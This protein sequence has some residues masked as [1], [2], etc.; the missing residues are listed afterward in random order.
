MKYG[1]IAKYKVKP[2]HEKHMTADMENFEQS[3]PEGWSHHTVLRS[4]TDPNEIWLCV[5]FDS[6]ESYKRNADSPDMDKEYRR[7]LEHLE[8]EPE[9]HDGHVIHE[10]M[11]QAGHQT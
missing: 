8:K 9:W 4:T 1:T 5:V 3:P 2:G 7:L 11:R 6:E 10:A